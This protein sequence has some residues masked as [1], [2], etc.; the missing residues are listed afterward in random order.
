MWSE[1]AIRVDTITTGE[2]KEHADDHG[3]NAS[4]NERNVRGQLEIENWFGQLSE[5]KE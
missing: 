2:A 1:A 5:H 3:G 4:E